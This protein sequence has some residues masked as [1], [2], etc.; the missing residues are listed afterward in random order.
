MTTTL[1]VL[2]ALI[3][4]T[5]GECTESY[6]DKSI[7]YIENNKAA[8]TIYYLGTKASA[9]QCR[10]S[11]IDFNYLCDKSSSSIM[12]FTTA[13]C[14]SISFNTATCEISLF[15]AAASEL[16]VKITDEP[17]LSSNYIIEV[18]LT[19]IEGF[20]AGLYWK[21]SNDMNNY[22]DYYFCMDPDDGCITGYDDPNDFVTIGA[23]PPAPSFN[24]RHTIRVTISGSSFTTELDGQLVYSGNLRSS[25]DPYG[26]AG[27]WTATA[28]AIFHSFK[29]T[30]PSGGN[31]EK[32]CTA[33]LL[34]ESNRCYGYYGTDFSSIQESISPK[35]DYHSGILYFPGDCPTPNPT[36]TPTAYP[37]KKATPNPTLKATVIPT[38][39]PTLKPTPNPTS[40]PTF[41]PTSFLL[42]AKNPSEPT[43][44]QAEGEGEVQTVGVTIS[45]NQ[46]QE[47]GDA[48]EENGEPTSMM[49]LSSAV[50]VVLCMF[51]LY[52]ESKKYKQEA[53]N[54]IDEVK[55]N[56]ID[57][58]KD[59]RI[60]EVK[61]ADDAD[62]ERMYNKVVLMMRMVQIPGTA[63]T[64]QTCEQTTDNRIDE[65]NSKDERMYDKVVQITQSTPT[66]TLPS[67]PSV[68]LSKTRLLV[69][70]D[71]ATSKGGSYV[72]ETATRGTM[73]GTTMDNNADI[74]MHS[75]CEEKCV[76]C[77]VTKAGKVFTDSNF[78]CHQCWMLYA[79]V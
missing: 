31:E 43:R 47:L 59:N 60:D 76:D 16:Y 67:A 23:G 37:S 66:H 48:P 35:S 12:C 13:T 32:I 7:T 29:V 24:T 50:I 77:G 6:I 18:E 11:C 64:P 3:T 40:D 38:H 21:G 56:H 57:E 20:E 34:D 79:D 49:V 22:Y 1:F 58:V 36:K 2:L 52:K 42:N 8:S 4:I 69:C 41:K 55:D 44:N 72:S 33:Y 51:C 46:L 71:E 17:I 19:Q 10:D 14:E 26:W 5:N 45:T 15:N 65:V 70:K 9:T 73:R 28:N 78:Y 68:Q 62:D 75:E 63:G 27:I 25:H 30:F 39:N 74:D 54:R 53:A 61:G